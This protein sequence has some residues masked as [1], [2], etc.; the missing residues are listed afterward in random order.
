MKDISI[1]CAYGTIK[2]LCWGSGNKKKI[3]ALHGWLDNAASFYQLAP[4]LA[5]MGYEVV[6][7]DFA[8]H[9]HSD[10]R[11][12]GHFT[13]FIDYVLDIQEVLEKLDWK[14]PILLGHSMGGAMAQMYTATN[15]Q[16]VE[17]L[18]II[19]NIGPVPAYESGTAASNLKEALKQ[20]RNHTTK[21][22]HFYPDI[23]TALQARLTVTPMPAQILEPMV[24]RGLIKT[25]EGYHWRTDKRLR[26]RSLFRFS[27]EI[28]QDALS[29]D[30]PPTQ[31][32]LAQPYTY[33][34]SYPTVQ[35]R[36]EKLNAD[37]TI[38]INGH[39]HLHM[40]NAAEVF[41]AIKNFIIK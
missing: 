34:L 31:L 41:T 6:A 9:G 17:K 37:E 1:T 28:V 8:G 40:E 11:A 10:H 29:A 16:Q 21:H 22:K 14:K 5:K 2:G 30:K 18:I 35:Q 39:H 33:A 3:L 27:E 38:K 26:L 20:W 7:I 23:H 15:P 19:E 12:K 24:S 4:L 13:H 36:I 32:I 25:V